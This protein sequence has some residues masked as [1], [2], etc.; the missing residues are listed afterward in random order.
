MP[1][2][3]R[4]RRQSAVVGRPEMEAPIT[5]K[6]DR[7]TRKVGNFAPALMGKV[8]PAFTLPLTTQVDD[9]VFLSRVDPALRRMAGP[10]APPLKPSNASSLI[11]APPFSQ[12]R[13]RHATAAA[14]QAGIPGS[15]IHAD[16][17]QSRRGCHTA[18][19]SSPTEAD[20]RK[21]ASRRIETMS[22]DVTCKSINRDGAG[23]RRDHERRPT[24]SAL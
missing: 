15:F 24:A 11:S 16:P 8:D 7:Q 17:D 9:A 13:A 2:S 18:P 10:P 6:A 23:R 14:R 4:R 22:A 3:L 21:G 12:G 1:Q 5:C 20:Y 19:L